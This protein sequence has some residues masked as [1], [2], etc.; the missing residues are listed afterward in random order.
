MISE[1]KSQ[2]AG[3]IVSFRMDSSFVDDLLLHVLY[4]FGLICSL[5]HYL[6]DN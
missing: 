4:A 5:I 3:L 6:I 1:K 2:M